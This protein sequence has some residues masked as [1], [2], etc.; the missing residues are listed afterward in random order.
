MSFRLN[1][2]LTAAGQLRSLEE[3]RDA[4]AAKLKR[5]R[6]CIGLLQQNPRH[7]GLRTHEFRSIRGAAGEK[8]WEAYVENNTPG[9]W[10]V[11]WPYGPEKDAITSV[12]ITP[13]P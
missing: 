7:P 6:K 10:R 5:V 13:H 2:T 3:G 12:A 11:F 8:V 1:L 9:A 4:N